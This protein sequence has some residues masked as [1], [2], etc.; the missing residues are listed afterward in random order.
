MSDWRERDHPRDEDGRFRGK[1]GWASAV[2]A[3]MMPGGHRY[4]QGQDRREEI[5]I[6]ELA[7]QAE[8]LS[9]AIQ[10]NGSEWGLPDDGL[11]GIYAL[12]G[13]HGK[14]EV[15]TELEMD[16]R[17]LAEGWEQVWR[18]FGKV[19]AN[20]QSEYLEAFRSGEEHWPGLGIYGNGTYTAEKFSEAR[21]YSEWTRPRQGMSFEEED[22]AYDDYRSHPGIA[23][24]AI[25]PEARAIYYYDVARLLRADR[26][27]K[28]ER[29]ARAMGDVGR[30]AALLGY[31][32]I[33]T[34]TEQI[35]IL[36]RTAVAVQ[37]AS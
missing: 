3:Q 29:W 23:R 30:Y 21:H 7:Q 36:N 34:D 33:T 1:S 4:V 37:G 10:A 25:N 18:G 31:D 9:A 24:I 13:Y 28:G 27:G 32:Y 2:V 6:E 8:A 17:I 5:D 35:I 14:P 11:R 12:Q 22:D 19:N 15:L 20:R 26:E 16:H